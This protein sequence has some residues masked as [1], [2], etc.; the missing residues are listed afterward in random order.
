[1]RVLLPMVAAVAIAFAGVAGAADLKSGLQPGEE[2]GAFTVEKC[3]GA[4]DDGVKVGQKLCYRC[5]LGARPMVMVFSRHADDKLAKL[6][7]ELDKTVTDKADAKLAAFVNLIGEDAGDLKTK[8]EKFEKNHKAGKIAIVVPQDQ[9]NG[10]EDYKISKDADVTVIIAKE[11][12]VEANY[13]LKAD[14]LNAEAIKKIVADAN[15]LVE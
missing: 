6:V 7:A 10:P 5:K 15:K 2:I 9:P 14:G 4:A 1:M 3:G 13:A 11:G 12:K 8:A